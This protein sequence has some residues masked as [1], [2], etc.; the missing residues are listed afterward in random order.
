M[1][2]PVRVLLAD[3]HG[4][5]RK[6]FRRL[7]ED[8]SNIL[9]AGEAGSGREALA[10]AE[11]LRPDVAVLDVS[12][13]DMDGLEAARELKRRYPSMA[14]LMVSMHADPAYAKTAREAGASG[15]VLKAA[16]ELDLEDAILR[17]A[18]GQLVF[19]EMQGAG[20][21]REAERLRA[22]TPRERQVLQLLASGKANKEIAAQLG[23]SVN[24]VAVHRARLMDTLGIR[25]TAELTLF[26]VRS[27]LVSPR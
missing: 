7:L 3:D 18:E 19:A 14:V 22:L 11:Q 17:V 23:V 2:D 16:A 13:P 21:S 27:G 24:T 12:M 25:G 20:E 9:V 15:Y 4:L 26:A 5:V 6:G 10:L 8:S 1:P